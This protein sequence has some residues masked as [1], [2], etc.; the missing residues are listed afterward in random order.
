MT[1]DFERR[2]RERL[3]AVAL[4][5]A[6]GRLRHRPMAIATAPAPVAAKPFT[7]LRFAG[8]LVAVL[9]LVLVGTAALVGGDHDDA[10]SP[11]AAAIAA[12]MVVPSPTDPAASTGPATPRIVCAEQI[13]VPGLRLTC[14]QAVD[15]ALAHLVAIGEDPPP[16]SRIEFTYGCRDVNGGA[17]DCATQLSGSVKVYSVSPDRLE[18]LSEGYGQTYVLFVQGN[19]TSATAELLYIQGFQ[20]FCEEAEPPALSCAEIVHTALAYGAFGADPGP[21]VNVDVYRFCDTTC[22]PAFKSVLVDVHLSS[23]I[24]TV[25][26]TVYPTPEGPAVQQLDSFLPRF[27]PPYGDEPSPELATAIEAVALRH[28]PTSGA[29]DLYVLTVEFYGN[30]CLERYEPWVGVTE[31][32][33]RVAI[34][35]FPQGIPCTVAAHLIIYTLELPS[36]FEGSLVEDLSSGRTFEVEIYQPRPAST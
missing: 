17:V 3:H 21:V 8:P 20:I 26:L 12:T 25:E 36:P 31:N 32:R 10:P 7:R 6:P 27:R 2:L 4:P 9:V 24:A 14:Q 13:D 34:V 18:P 11:S 35:A 33:V 28:E 29:A 16:S 23:E 15:A 1:D 19:G 5:P 30:T 22:E